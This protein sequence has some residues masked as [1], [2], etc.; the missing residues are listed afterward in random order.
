MQQGRVFGNHLARV[1]CRGRERF[2]FVVWVDGTGASMVDAQEFLLEVIDGEG[3]M[4]VSAVSADN[5][6][7]DYGDIDD[8]SLGETP[9]LPWI[10]RMVKLGC[11][12]TITLFRAALIA[13][14]ELTLVAPDERLA[15]ILNTAQIAHCDNALAWELEAL[16]AAL[17]LSR[18]EEARSIR[19]IEKRALLAKMIADKLNSDDAA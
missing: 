3:R 13:C 10:K 18:N 17:Q 6:V 19:E 2:G 5:V 4:P 11:V 7:R 15:R 16:K 12:N 1:H 8:L 14:G 9:Y